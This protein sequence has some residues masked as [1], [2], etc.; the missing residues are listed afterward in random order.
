MLVYMRMCEAFGIAVTAE[1]AAALRIRN[2][3]AY[4]KAKEGSGQK[5][6]DR[7]GEIYI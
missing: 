1:E 4:V 2:E 3:Q 6:Y 5:S 7:W